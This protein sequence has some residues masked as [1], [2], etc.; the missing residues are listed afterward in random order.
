VRLDLSPAQQ[1]GF[2][3]ANTAGTPKPSLKRQKAGSEKQEIGNSQQTP[4][5]GNCTD[6]LDRMSGKAV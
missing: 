1:D 6:A 2:L 5:A 3:C 4:A